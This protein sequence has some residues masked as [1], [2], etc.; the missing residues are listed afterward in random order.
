M[1]KIYQTAPSQYSILTKGAPEQILKISTESEAQQ[2]KI[3]AHVSKLAGQGYR[4]LAVAYRDL[5]EAETRD[6]ALSAEKDLT[7]VGLIALADPLREEALLSIQKCQEAGIRTMIVTGDHRHTAAYIGKKLGIIQ[8]EDEVGDNETLEQMSESE[9]TQAVNQYSVLSRISPHV[10]LKIVESLKKEGEIVA[11]TGDGVNDAPA[12]K[13]SSVGIAMG[14]TGTDVAKEAADIVLA[15]D[16]FATIVS[17]VE[18]GRNIY[19]NII[20][21]I[22]YL[23]S[24]NMG[25]IFIMLLSTLFALPLPFLPIHILWLNLVTDT[26]PAL[27]LGVDPA[28]SDIMKHPPRRPKEMILSREM[29]NAILIN[30][31]IMALITLGI[32]IFEL[33]WM[34]HDITKARTIAF[35]NIVFVQLLHAF[36]C[37]HNRK[38]IFSMGFFTNSY[39][40]VAILI[41]FGLLLLSIYQ[42]FMRQTF[43]L[44]L[45]NFTDWMHAGLASLIIIVA[46]E[47][48]KKWFTSDTSRKGPPVPGMKRSQ[49]SP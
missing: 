13:R 39:L 36:N 20:K 19:N 33:K 15:D 18:E 44:S 47:I 3:I 16:N 34:E 21:F 40:I 38:S 31:F 37:Q 24:C 14:K 32:F 48:Q 43:H 28:P 1:S 23:L 9:F 22:R 2:Q 17:A 49:S 4:V 25:E 41:S 30:G 10:K 27:A 42:P 8:S 46:V 29:M 7:Y 5:S 45:L 6:T 12:I 26:P 35:A 11:M